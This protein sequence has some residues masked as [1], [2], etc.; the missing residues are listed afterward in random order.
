MGLFDK[1][2]GT[3]SD[4]EL[5]RIYP[6]ADRIEALADKTAARDALRAE[7]ESLAGRIAAAEGGE[8]SRRRDSRPKRVRNGNGLRS[9][10]RI[11]S[12]AR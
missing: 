8:P 4:R 7:A 11:P 5:K 2:F 3:Y 6:I 1:L 10:S 9:V 12:E